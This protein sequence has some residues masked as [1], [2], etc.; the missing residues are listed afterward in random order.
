MQFTRRIMTEIE[1][2]VGLPEKNIALEIKRKGTSQEYKR[3]S[4]TASSLGMNEW[5]IVSQLFTADEGMIPA[6]D[7]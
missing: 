4:K 3:L 7:L 5:Y 2:Q 1:A 6:L